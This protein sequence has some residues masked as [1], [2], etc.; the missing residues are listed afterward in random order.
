M[1]INASIGGGVLR[2]LVPALV[3]TLLAPSCAAPVAGAPPAIAQPIAPGV[4][5]PSVATPA[6]EVRGCPPL[7][8]AAPNPALGAVPVAM[9][10]LCRDLYVEA[11]LA[12]SDRERVARFYDSA[13]ADVE[14]GLGPLESAPPLALFCKT[15]ACATYFGGVHH[16]SRVLPPGRRAEGAG[17]VAGPRVTILILRVDEK[18][19]GVLAHERV[20][21]EVMTRLGRA[22]RPTW[23]DEGLAAFVGGEP[24]CEAQMRAGIDDLRRLET[25]AAWSEYTNIP[26]T[27]E[28]TYCQARAE[29]AAWQERSGPGGLVELLRKV[30]A[31]A[32]FGDVYGAMQSQP[33]TPPDTVITSLATS[34]GDAKRPFSLA[35]WI[36]PAA[37]GGVLAHVSAT[38]VG[39]G[40]CGPLLGFDEDKHL[41]AQ[42]LQAPSPDLASFARA[43]DPKVRATGVWTHVAMTWSPASGNRLYV[44]GA[45]AASS[46][47]PSYFAPSD[48]L[49]AFVAWGSSNV[50][51]ANC[52]HGGVARG[53]FQGLVA[54]VRVV[55]GELDPAA[56]AALARTPP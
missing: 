28:P 11:A 19:R 50:G 17:Y 45:L 29:V 38:P 2:G 25:G 54:D 3:F 30:R 4:S 43:T 20:H 46:P 21:V 44:G 6:F 32:A 22:H 39:T 14:R 18:A 47:A 10:P 53:A 40:W 1:T 7:D 16:R 52:W 27:M 12:Q 37:L 34:L 51:G 5:A 35:L 26:G 42:V 15:E 33:A 55:S 49:P 36:K 48:G 31:G 56:I 24:T 23:F 13:R 8:P 9:V 41:V